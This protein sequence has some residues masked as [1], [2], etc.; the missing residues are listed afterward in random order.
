MQTLRFNSLEVRLAETASEVDAA[1]ALR[2]RIFYDEMGAKPTP[3]RE[4]LMRDVDPYD[5]ICDHLLVIDL[6]RGTAAAPEVVGTYRLL[7]GTVAEATAGFYSEGEFDLAGLLHHPGEIMELGRS[8]INAEYRRRGAMQLLWRGIADYIFEHKVE[9]MFGC[10]SI[11]GTDTDEAKRALAFL[12]HYH[13][14][15]KGLRPRAL[16]SRYVEMNTMKK[17][18]IDAKLAEQELP[19]LLKGYLR[20]GGYVGDG[21]VI[22]YQF[23][24]I[25]VCV[26]VETEKVTGKYIRHFAKDKLTDGKV[27]GFP[28][29]AQ[30]VQ[31]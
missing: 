1:Q 19:P 6:E 14:A 21:A 8:C 2:Y 23:N 15:P 17:K 4:K 7:R 13:R 3:N 10:G 20:L 5:D 11:H 30:A 16:D 26:V 12:H 31:R 29:M 24:T 18:H 25:D 9:V 28:A 22:D 27:A